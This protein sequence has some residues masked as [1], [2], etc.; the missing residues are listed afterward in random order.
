[1]G[2]FD[3]GVQQLQRIL[4]NEVASF[5]HRLALLSTCRQTYHDT[6]GLPFELNELRF[7]TLRDFE[8]TIVNLL[9]SQR[10]H[11]RHISLG[12]DVGTRT[13]GIVE[14]VDNLIHNMRLLGFESLLH[15]L[16]NVTRV[17]VLF[18]DCRM[19]RNPVG[20]SFRAEVDIWKDMQARW[21]EGETQLLR[22]L[23][24]GGE[25][26]EVLATEA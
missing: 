15:L 12:H 8:R 18:G 10:Q 14:G 22:W 26:V 6:E 21:M 9:P 19:P 13:M 1:L 4:S 24:G 11:I 7:P 2:D 3:D 25:E 16:P 17:A 5:K 20:M 23:R